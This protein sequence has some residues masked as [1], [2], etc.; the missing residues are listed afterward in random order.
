MQAA[1]APYLCQ[2]IWKRFC[3]F[4]YNSAAELVGAS[5]TYILV[6]VGFLVLIINLVFA[7]KVD[8]FFDRGKVVPHNNSFDRS[9]MQGGRMN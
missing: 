3:R 2:S 1:D 9:R 5:I 7:K 4:E 6:S 8:A